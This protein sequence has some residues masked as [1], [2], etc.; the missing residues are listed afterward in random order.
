MLVQVSIMMH[1]VTK[2]KKKKHQKT[3][4]TEKDK[5]NANKGWGGGEVEGTEDVE[6]GIVKRISYI[7]W[8]A[9]DETQ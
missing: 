1:P 3:G 6:G 8:N 4:A 9:F 5:T 7:K 2:Q